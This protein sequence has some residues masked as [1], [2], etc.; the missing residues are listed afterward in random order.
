MKNKI[1]NVSALTLNTPTPGYPGYVQSLIF[2]KNIVG[3]GINPHI[4]SFSPLVLEIVN[5]SG[6][7]LDWNLVYSEAELNE[8]KL[9]WDPGPAQFYE[10]LTIP[11]NETLKLPLYGNTL[12]HVHSIVL[13]PQTPAINS[14]TIRAIH[15]TRK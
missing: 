8:L 1:L 3:P 13:R 6:V 4:E 14:I 12:G 2:T 5:T 15:L 9:D 7:A 10:F 11:S